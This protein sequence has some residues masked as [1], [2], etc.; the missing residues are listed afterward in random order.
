MNLK[1]L[2]N[3]EKAFLIMI[4]NNKLKHQKVSLNRIKVL[5]KIFKK[6]KE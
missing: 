2:V 5:K 6:F 3:K 1:N 4:N